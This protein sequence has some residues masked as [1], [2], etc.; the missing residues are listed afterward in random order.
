MDNNGP[1]NDSVTD[2]SVTWSMFIAAI[3]AAGGPA[4]E[5]RQI[6]PVDDADGGVPGGNIRVGFLFRTDRGLKFIDRPGG[7]ATTPTAVVQT[8]K[9]PALTLSPGRVDPSNPAWAVPEGVRKPLAGEFKARGKTLFLIANHW[10]SKTGDQPLFGRFQP[11]VQTTEPQRVA[12]AN[13]VKAFVDDILAL[14]SHANVV[15]LGDLNDFEFSHA[16]TAL[17]GGGDLHALVETLPQSERYSYVFEGNS[18][19]LDHIVVSDNLFSHFPFAYD[20]VHVNSEFAVQA[21]D[22]EPQVARFR[23][24]G[25]PEPR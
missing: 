23:L 13:V 22:H 12:E 3:Q 2:A 10:K 16:V 19:T 14:D 25:R 21:S 20:I 6:D 4:Y 8:N 9:G 5:Y 24:T 17:E 1:V 11:P 15:V 7:D 18:Q